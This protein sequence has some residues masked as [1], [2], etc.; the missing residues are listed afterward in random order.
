MADPTHRIVISES[1]LNEVTEALTTVP[2]TKSIRSFYAKLKVLAAKIDAGVKTPDYI[3]SNIR[4]TTKISLE[5][6]TASDSEAPKKISPTTVSMSEDEMFAE[7]ERQEKE[8]LAQMAAEGNKNV[9]LH[10]RRASPRDTGNTGDNSNDN[11]N[12]A[13]T[14]LFNS[15]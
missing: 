15:L 11:S 3:K 13:D 8:M 7:L 14:N 2:S 9:I 12:S 4:E 6:L 10:E 5:N 1:E